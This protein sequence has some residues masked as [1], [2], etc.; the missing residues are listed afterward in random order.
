M[1]KRQVVKQVDMHEESSAFSEENNTNGCCT[2][3]MK[4]SYC[5]C[6][7]PDLPSEGSFCAPGPEPEGIIQRIDERLGGSSHGIAHTNTTAFGSDQD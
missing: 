5:D 1:L 3:S 7:I 6:N 2:V 4:R